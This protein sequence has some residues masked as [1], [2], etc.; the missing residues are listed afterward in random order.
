[1]TTTSPSHKTENQSTL[2]RIP[3][4]VK[5]DTQKQNDTSPSTDNGK[6]T[7]G[8]K[9]F[10][11]ITIGLF[12]GVGTFFA[13][14]FFAYLA[15]FSSVKMPLTGGKKFSEKWSEWGEKVGD[16]ALMTTAL[17]MG[18]NLFLFPIKWMEERKQSVVEYFNKKFGTE[19]DVKRGNERVQDAPKQSWA[20][21]IPG[22]L[23]A[24]AVVFGSLTSI[25]HFTKTSD[26]K[27]ATY[28]DP[29][30]APKNLLHKMEMAF[31][32]K[33]EQAGN[34]L[35]PNAS[36]K[37][38]HRIRKF[39]ELTAVDLFATI[40]AASLL[41]IFSKIFAKRSH[42]NNEAEPQKRPIEIPRTL[43]KTAPDERPISQEEFTRDFTPIGKTGATRESSQ[44]PSTAKT[45]LADRVEART[46]DYRQQ[47]RDTKNRATE[48]LSAATAAM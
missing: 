40:A 12:A 29:D 7:I 20:S 36:D 21:L 42:K 16:D 37:A 28:A 30:K 18:G 34:K 39:G 11:G 46:G 14:I 44:Q 4:H 23:L 8:E 32:D 43:P 41:S 1:M 35:M 22:R 2:S 48:Q 33:F 45:E 15:K 27:R 19:E 10:G 17:M 24:W 31:G 13:S 5:E 9:I 25:A 26:E 47:R 6:K 3:H 38:R